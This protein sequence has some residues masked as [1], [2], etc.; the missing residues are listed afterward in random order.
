LPSYIDGL[1][2]RKC[3]ATWQTLGR[4]VI[5][6]TQRRTLV[7]ARRLNG[8]TDGRA[9]WHQACSRAIV[10][11]RKGQAGFTLIEL[12]VVVAIIGILAAIAIP[13]FNYRKNAFD[14][15]T[16]SDLRNAATA[17]ETYFADHT[18]YSSACSTLPGFNTS[19]GVVFTSCTGD[20]SAF[21][22]V[23]THPNG[24]KT[25]TWDSSASPPLSCS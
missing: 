13:Q 8:L 11:R 10:M 18:M 15:R 1:A 25:C 6:A 5:L 20:P 22:M 2:A 3:A 24:T 23:A 19:N 9:G 21:R 4:S 14:A 7:A 17:Q 16:V 12:L